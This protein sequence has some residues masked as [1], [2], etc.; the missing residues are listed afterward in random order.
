MTKTEKER[1][2]NRS[3][4]TGKERE[5]DHSIETEKEIEREK[6]HSIKRNGTFGNEAENARENA[7]EK[8]Y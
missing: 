8:N 1:E 2:K 4:K 6:N 7:T 3:I 5:K